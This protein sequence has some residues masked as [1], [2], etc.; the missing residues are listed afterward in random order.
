MKIG[1]FMLLIKLMNKV[2][3]TQLILKNLKIKL[4]FLQ[5]YVEENGK[6][7]VKLLKNNDNILKKNDK[8]T[9]FWLLNLLIIQ[10][11]MIII[12]LINFYFEKILK[13]F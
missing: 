2:G 1:K 8:I 13:F 7:V 9:K 10:L 12:I 6:E 3:N 11:F 5:V 4:L